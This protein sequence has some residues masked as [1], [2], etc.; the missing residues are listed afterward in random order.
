[1]TVGIPIYNGERHLAEALESVVSQDYPNVE[2][3][4]IDDAST[5]RSAEI[6]RAFM[7]RDPRVTFIQNRHNVGAIPNS[8][9]ALGVARGTYFTW[10][11]Q[12]NAFASPRYLSTTIRFLEE[13]PDTACCSSWFLLVDFEGPGTCVELP[14]TDIE[15]DVPWPRARQALFRALVSPTIY[16]LSGVFRRDALLNTVARQF[17]SR[18]RFQAAG[19]EWRYLSVVSAYGRVVA[20]PEPLR[21]FRMTPG[22]LADRNRRGMSTFDR[23]WLRLNLRIFLLYTALQPPYSRAETPGIVRTAVSNFFLE[24]VGGTADDRHVRQMF[25]DEVATLRDATAERSRVVD[26]LSAEIAK[27]R[28]ALGEA[29]RAVPTTSVPPIDTPRAT[30]APP[31]VVSPAGGRLG[32]LYARVFLPP[33]QDLAD[34][35]QWLREELGRLRQQCDTQ[36]ETIEHL[37]SEARALLAIMEAAAPAV[38]GGGD[39]HD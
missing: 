36:L 3:I 13:H 16:A 32:R 8:N 4:A 7:A 6:V 27:R 33:P 37:D 38:P 9:R 23:A 11:A 20:L 19:M 28:A 31:A 30:V 1:M 17:P 26:L 34:Y 25:E 15:P 10:L 24:Y 22:G 12:D 35:V 14:L 29:A 21:T 18:E 2:I 39:D 5:D